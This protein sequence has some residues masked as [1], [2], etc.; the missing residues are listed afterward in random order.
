MSTVTGLPV[1]LK[2]KNGD[3]RFPFTNNFPKDTVPTSASVN[4]LDS[5]SSI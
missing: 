4:M 2:D 1:Q 3:V 5:R